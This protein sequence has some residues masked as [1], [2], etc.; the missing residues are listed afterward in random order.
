MRTTQRLFP[1]DWLRVTCIEL[2]LTQTQ[3]VLYTRRSMSEIT[4]RPLELLDLPMLQR[5]LNQDEYEHDNTKAYT[6]DAAFSKVYE[7]E[8]GPIGILRYTK[9]LRLVTVWCDNH[10][11]K[12][13]AASVI[14][15]IADSV[16]LAKEN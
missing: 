5:A 13:N 14:K 4:S 15:A 11:R 2:V 16:A 9:T 3:F 6:K 12:R 10:D 1:G 7:D 8:D